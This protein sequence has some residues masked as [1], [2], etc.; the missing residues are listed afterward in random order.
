VKNFESGWNLLGSFYISADT[1]V[2]SLSDA[3]G[4]DR[5]VADAVK[6]VQQR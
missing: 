1:A 6:W 4:A 5:V 3:G 2:V